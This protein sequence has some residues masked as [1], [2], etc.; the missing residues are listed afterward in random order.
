[1]VWNGG[2]FLDRT[3]VKWSKEETILA[4]DLYCRTSF[5]RISSSNK[6]IRE[7][8]VLLGRSPGSVALKMHNLAHFDPELQERNIVAMSH[9]SKLDFAV[10]TEFNENWTELSY[11]ARN[12]LAQL[13]NEAVEKMVVEPEI[14]CLPEGETKNQL[15]KTRIGQ[16]FFRTTVLNA[17]ENKCCITGLSYPELL[18]ASHIKPWKDSDSKIERTNPMNGL[19]LNAL[20]DKAFDRGLITITPDYIIH[21]SS[22]IKLA[23]NNNQTNEWFTSYDKNRIIIPNKF[24]PKREFLEY[25]NDVI[26]EG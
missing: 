11:L 26:F 24:A 25:H 18:V 4:F 20:H 15:I 12:L 7:L 13:K 21:V 10:W 16:H 5:G 14:E 9:G 6:D 8:A 23:F 2:D 22:K 1:M 3:G 19:S 17:Y